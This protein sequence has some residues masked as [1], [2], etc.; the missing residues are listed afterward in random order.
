MREIFGLL[1]VRLSEFKKSHKTQFA[2]CVSLLQQYGVI[3]THCKILVSNNQGE[4][5]PFT[6]VFRTVARDAFS[7]EKPKV[8]LQSLGLN[9]Q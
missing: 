4:G 7:K 6:D 2:R 1:P 9:I 3:A 5:M 8:W